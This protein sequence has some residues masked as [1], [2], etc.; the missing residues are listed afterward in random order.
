MT[1]APGTSE[2]AVIAGNVKRELT[3]ARYRRASFAAFPA[4]TAFY[5]LTARSAAIA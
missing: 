2:S 4:I 5:R 1:T 3:H